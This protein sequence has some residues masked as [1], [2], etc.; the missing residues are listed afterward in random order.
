MKDADA[1]S[2]KRKLLNAIDDLAQKREAQKEAARL[3]A[4]AEAARIA[5]RNLP[6]PAMFELPPVRPTPKP[7]RDASQLPH[8]TP[9]PDGVPFVCR[10]PNCRATIVA[11]WSSKGNAA[12][13]NYD[14]DFKD[15]I[16]HAVCP[17]RDLFKRKR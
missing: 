9:D 16:H 7:P 5:A 14:G 3:E 12:V 2:S 15:V 13:L 6:Q 17:D 10:G 1:T 11:G 4:A 8:G